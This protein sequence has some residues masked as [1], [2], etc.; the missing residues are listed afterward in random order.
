MEIRCIKGMYRLKLVSSR[1]NLVFKG[2][3]G[4]RPTLASQKGDFSHYYVA[5]PGTNR[6]SFIFGIA[7]ILPCF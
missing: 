3:N 6:T 4:V 1:N 7:I 5:V 2:F